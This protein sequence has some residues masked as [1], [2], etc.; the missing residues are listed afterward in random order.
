MK[1]IY[2]VSLNLSVYGSNGCKVKSTQV[3]TTVYDSREKALESVNKYIKSNSSLEVI[4]YEIHECYL[5]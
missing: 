4:S 5:Y 3:L 1:K 2:V